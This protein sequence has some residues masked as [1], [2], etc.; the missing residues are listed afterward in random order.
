MNKSFPANQMINCCLLKLTE[1]IVPFN[2]I[3]E[4]ER[5]QKSHLKVGAINKLLKR[6]CGSF[7][8]SVSPPQSICRVISL[9]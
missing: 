1:G 8:S 4:D 7:I 2:E 5:N 3:S 9:V 6:T